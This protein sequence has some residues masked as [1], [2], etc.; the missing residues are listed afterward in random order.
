M[1]GFVH[2][3]LQNPSCSCKLLSSVTGSVGA[4]VPVSFL[5]II[6]LHAVTWCV[7]GLKHI[8]F[9]SS[10][11]FLG[12]KARNKFSV[13]ILNIC[14]LFLL[15]RLLPTVGVQKTLLSHPRLCHRLSKV[16]ETITIETKLESKFFELT[17]RNSFNS[18]LPIV[19]DHWG[20]S[21][22]FQLNNFVRLF[23]GGR[24]CGTAG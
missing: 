13:D 22:Q 14:L 21:S 9:V 3:Q 19:T 20:S 6:I 8:L 17:I 5:Q 10:Y 16:L 23:L 24:P 4:G 2:Y 15:P 1:K 12:I 18:L 7:C 11:L